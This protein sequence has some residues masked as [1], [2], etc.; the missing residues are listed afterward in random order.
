MSLFQVLMGLFTLLCFLWCAWKCARR[1]GRY[2][3]TVNGLLALVW[4]SACVLILNPELAT[5]VAGI[6]GIKRGVDLVL[7]VFVILAFFYAMITY[8]RLCDIRK[9]IT[10]IVRHI[11]IAEHKIPAEKE[12]VEL[13][14]NNALQEHERQ[15]KV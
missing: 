12:R 11:A 8:Y 7:Y 4:A 10:L 9:D 15:P 6:F 3:R 2:A 1:P 13:K 14:E 5:V